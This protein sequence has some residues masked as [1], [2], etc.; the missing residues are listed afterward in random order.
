MAQIPIV[1]L[2]EGVEQ[3]Q[4]QQPPQPQPSGGWSHLSQHRSTLTLWSCSTYIKD[5]PH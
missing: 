5:E 3:Q 2:Q 1:V 4:Q